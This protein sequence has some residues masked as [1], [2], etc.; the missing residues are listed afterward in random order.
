MQIMDEIEL[1]KLI[2]GELDRSQQK[3]LLCQLDR[4]SSQWRVVAL[5]LLEEQEF[6][7]EL[8]SGTSKIND[9]LTTL[10][11][12]N[13]DDELKS[14]PPKS[15][16]SIGNNKVQH[17]LPMALAASLLIG[18]G[19][20]G[21]NWLAS[22]FDSNPPTKVDGAPSSVAISER[23]T[24][25]PAELNYALLKPV[26]QLSFSSDGAA[27]T[28]V[29]P[30]Q[31]PIY[32]AAPDQINQM[33]QMQQRQMQALNEQLRRQGF[34]LDW[35][36]EMLESRLPDGRAVIVPVQQINVRSFGQ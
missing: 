19:S 23:K 5:A 33:L 6:R 12:S 14:S 9:T 34:E 26:G 21:G 17:W 30:V 31:L 22:Q 25:D 24:S 10:A 15:I 4:E 36:P 8:G 20:I 35:R 16:P 2:D 28:N 3:Q 29:T 13:S 11:Q 1:Q 32:E 27:N 7:R 18:I